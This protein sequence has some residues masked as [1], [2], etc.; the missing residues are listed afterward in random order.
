MSPS[1]IIQG[2]AGI[3]SD[4]GRADYA[5]LYEGLG[6]AQDVISW[7]LGLLIIFVLIGFSVVVALE[8]LFL[9]LPLFQSSIYKAMEKNDVAN[10]ILGLCFRDAKR[11]I[12]LANTSET[13]K[14]ANRVYLG[15]KIKVIFIV[16]LIIGMIL[17]PGVWVIQSIMGIVSDFLSAF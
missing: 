17:G 5:T 1:E 14:S 10:K 3:M 15:I 2:I 12:I 6:I 8:V 9:N 11:A 4:D 13:G 7:I 16:F